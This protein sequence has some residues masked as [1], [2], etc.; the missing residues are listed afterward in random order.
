[1]D[2]HTL[3]ISCVLLLIVF[4]LAVVVLPALQKRENVI[5]RII[6]DGYTARGRILNIE[7]TGNYKMGQP[8]LRLDLR[9]EKPTQLPFEAAVTVTV[10]TIYRSRFQ[11]GSAVNV[12][13]L[14]NRK[15]RHIAVKGTMEYP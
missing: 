7:P 11:E 2:P 9:I 5:E 1:M 15:G 12:K 3:I 10:Y 8:E 4:V 6:Q 14:E 13:V